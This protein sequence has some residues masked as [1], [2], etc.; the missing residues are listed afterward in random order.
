M[1]F[2]YFSVVLSDTWKSIAILYQSRYHI[3]FSFF[4][5][6]L[7][8]CILVICH[9]TIYMKNFIQY[10]TLTSW[11]YREENLTSFRM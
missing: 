9:Y 4:V 11:Y 8:A 3:N 2:V 5:G 6:I 10:D 7:L 1:Q